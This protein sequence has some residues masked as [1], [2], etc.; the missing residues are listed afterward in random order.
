[1]DSNNIDKDDS[2]SIRYIPHQVDYMRD[3]FRPKQFVKESKLNQEESTKESTVKENDKQ[4]MYTS[5][6]GGLKD[7]SD[8][9]LNNYEVIQEKSQ[10]RTK[11]MEDYYQHILQIESKHIDLEK[12]DIKKSE[13]VHFEVHHCGCEECSP[14]FYED[15]SM[16]C[17]LCTMDIP[18][19]QWIDHSRSICHQYKQ[20]QKVHVY[21]NPYMN[22]SSNAFQLMTKMGWEEGKGLGIKGQ[23][24][25]QPIATRLKQNHLGVGAYDPA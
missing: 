17:A 8:N 22:P 23:G 20:K 18:D 21:V 10:L 25:L 19:G 1:M 12:E 9:K 24:R 15:G 3:Y 11:D 7:I 5:I 2:S 16:Y 13:D 4:T 6:Y 14:R